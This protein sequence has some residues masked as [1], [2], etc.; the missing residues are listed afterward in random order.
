MSANLTG[1]NREVKTPFRFY[2]DERLMN[3]YKI[4]CR[5]MVNNG[6]C[7]FAL[8][9]PP[10]SLLPFQIP[11][12]VAIGG[13]TS[14]LIKDLSGT[15]IYDLSSK[16]SLIEWIKF[17]GFHYFIYKGDDLGILLDPGVYMCEI[18]DGTSIWYSELFKPV[19]G[20]EGSIITNDPSFDQEET[21]DAYAVFPTG[22]VDYFPGYYEFTSVNNR[23]ISQ[24]V[25]FPVNFATYKVRIILSDVTS[26]NLEIRCGDGSIKILSSSGTFDFLMTSAS[27]KTIYIVGKDGFSGKLNYAA[28]SA[29]TS[30]LSD[31]HMK[32]TWKRTCGSLG[33]TYYGS[34][35]EN[36]LYLEKGCD[37][38]E[39]SARNIIEAS[40]NGD[41]EQIETFKRR[42]TTYKIELGYLPWYLLDALYEIRL[43]D[44]VT[45]TQTENLGTS[46]IV[47][48][49]VNASWDDVGGKCL[50]NTVL[51]FELDE[52]SITD[53]CCDQWEIEEPVQCQT[54]CITASGFITDST[55]VQLDYYLDTNSQQYYQRN[56]LNTGFLEPVSCDSGMAIYSPDSGSEFTSDMY[57]FI[58]GTW[59]S[60]AS[61]F[62]ADL[63]AGI[64]SLF[65]NIL[66]GWLGALQISEDN[67]ATWST[68]SG[69]ENAAVWSVT[70]VQAGAPSGILFRVRLRAPNGCEY[71]GPVNSS[72]N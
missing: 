55:F 72:F 70:G 54:P 62:G 47:Q 61:Y 42:E 57:V 33:N 21:W 13:L 50:A 39:G 67:G 16:I 44:V 34:G 69:Y 20:T 9:S 5:N 60:I 45:L 7:E 59:Q 23:G 53:G 17:V 22:S 43:N 36:V 2:S 24:L 56:A 10:T 64:L 27:N 66:P 37:M 38:I 49:A 48:P 68:I 40:E 18:S 29:Y 25:N 52:A 3:R 28:S 1:L 35:Y 14:W 30:G 31:C 46:L 65:A 41:K 71:N 26:G 58:G 11:R 15:T 19:C 32:L 51:A 8:I 12:S 63:N 6:M 4:D